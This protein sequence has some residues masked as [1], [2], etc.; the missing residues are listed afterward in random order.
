M[1][2]LQH[3]PREGV[4]TLLAL[5][6]HGVV[7]AALGMGRFW[8]KGVPIGDRH[9]ALVEQWP[10]PR[11]HDVELLIVVPADVVGAQHLQALPHRQVGA[12][13]ENCIWKAVVSRH[14][15]SVTEGPGDDHRHDHRF[16]GACRHLAADACE[17]LPVFSCLHV[18]EARE[19]SIAH[20]VRECGLLAS[21]HLLVI[22]HRHI[23]IATDRAASGEDLVDV[24]DRL[25]CFDLAEKQPS[26]SVL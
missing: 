11:R 18:A 24:N 23:R 4:G 17:R 9:L 1:Q 22:P 21:Q 26:S 2:V 8:R 25:D 10:H 13:N 7:R 12:A 6:H 19:E 5:V 14:S 3:T 20:H 15:A 16:A